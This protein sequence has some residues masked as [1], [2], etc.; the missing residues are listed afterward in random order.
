[1]KTTELKVKLESETSAQK[2]IGEKAEIAKELFDSYNRELNET[3]HYYIDNDIELDARYADEYIMDQLHKKGYSKTYTKQNDIGIFKVET[4]TTPQG[5]LIIN[6]KEIVREWD[7]MD[8]GTP[9]PQ[10]IVK[11]ILIEFD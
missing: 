1:M 10:T 8:M 4:I 11:C 3:Y 7:V 2:F 6:K 9:L 5:V